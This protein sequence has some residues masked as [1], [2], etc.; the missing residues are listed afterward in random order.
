MKT[1]YTLNVISLMALF[2]MVPCA[3]AEPD[4]YPGDTSIYG[5]SSALQPNLLIALDTSSS[6]REVIS[7]GS[8]DSNTIY[9]PT[10]MGCTSATTG[11]VGTMNCVAGNVYLISNTVGDL[12]GNS[13][14][15]GVSTPLSSVSN[16]S[17]GGLT[18]SSLSSSGYH[19]SGSKQLN[20]NGSCGSNST[21][22]Y[23]TGNYLNYLNSPSS[24]IVTKADAAIRVLKNMVSSSPNIKFGLMTFYKDEDPSAT[25]G[26][27]FMN[28]TGAPASSST[29]YITSV[30]KMGDPF[31]TSSSTTANKNALMAAIDAIKF[32]WPTTS[33]P[34]GETTAIGTFPGQLLLEA[35]RSY[36]NCDAAGNNCGAPA[37]NS[38]I[39]V[40]SG[41]LTTAT[42]PIE[43]TCQKNYVILITDGL[44]NRDGYTTTQANLLKTICDATSCAPDGCKGTGC[45]NFP[46]GNHNTGVNN[47]TSAI[48][49]YLYNSTQNISTY[50]IGFGLTGSDADAIAMLGIASDSTHGRGKYYN[51]G[52]EA[53]LTKSLL[54]IVS[55]INEVNSTFV[56]PVVPVSPQNR[57]YGASRVYM[58]FFTPQTGAPWQ[59][60]LKKYGLSSTSNI[61]DSSTPSTYATWVDSIAPFGT[62]DNTAASI[63]AGLANGSF[64]SASQSYWSTTVDGGNVDKG[65]VGEKLHS[66]AIPSPRTIYT[67]TSTAS[68]AL[69]VFNATNVTAA[70]LGV[71]DTTARDKLVSYMY[72]AD[73]Y[74]NNSNSDTT[75]NRDW[76]MGDVLHSRPV[77]VNYAAYAFTSTNEAICA[78][79]KS[80]IFVGS[81]D[82]MLH[83]FKD[84]DGSEAWA[85]VPPD[86]LPTLQ[87]IPSGTGHSYYVDSSVSTYA[88]NK[89]NDG[90]IN[91]TNGDKVVLVFGEGR[92]GGSAGSPTTGSYYALNVSDPQTPTLMWTLSNATSGFSELAETWSEPKIVKMRIGTADK[93]AAVFG[94]GYDNPHEDGRYGAIQNFS[95]IDTGV[96]GSATGSGNITSSSGTGTAPFYTNAKGRGIYVVE[97]A[98]LSTGVPTL[99][100]TLTKIWSYTYGSSPATATT[101]PGLVYS[102]PTNLAT[103]DADS[104]GYTT[105]IYA[106]DTGGNMWRFNLSSTSTS[107]WTGTKIFSANPT[108]GTDI[109]RKIFYAPAVVSEVGYK[110]LFFGTGDREHPLNLVVT[111]RMY[112]L[113][114]SGQTVTKTE[115]NMLDVTS[116]QI[117]ETDTSNVAGTTLVANALNTLNSASNYGWYIKLNETANNGE[118]VLS[119]PTVFNKAAYFTTFKPGSAAT[120]TS[121]SSD[122]GVATLYALNYKNGNAVINYDHTNDSNATVNKNARNSSGEVL[123]KSDRKQSLG[124]GIPS[125]VVV[126]VGADGTVKALTSTGGNI[127]NIDPLKGGTII[128]MYWRQK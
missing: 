37:F 8:Y 25:G 119:A 1:R 26:G 69:A 113:K 114:D 78:T 86:L 24:I 64:R 103:I 127:I 96:A 77:V 30:K 2:F 40:V 38:T 93:I 65:G 39:G 11:N 31:P 62:D 74:D 35:G 125:G 29:P 46:I 120:T 102:F 20:S 9:T 43:A 115:S 15:T 59:G 56:A 13:I 27:Q 122:V 84:C 68:T 60:N 90:T 49:K 34:A 110:M 23:A 87:N 22:S 72:G 42:S 45:S 107:S 95:G 75:E 19:L 33:V 50:T 61:L 116:D 89:A 63:P 16:S 44:A 28:F 21:K 92:G 85:F 67:M 104:S 18:R 111:D 54:Q 108:T 112:G 5:V 57:T 70:M 32:A 71:A 100:S 105:R 14:A 117:Q 76:F 52:D 58:G 55:S 10:V 73:A 79:N 51:A 124:S 17:C 36:G 53:G 98:T 12:V 3:F 83:A 106:G 109:G 81:N 47:A 80:M 121:C 82:G 94:A 126:I 7:G 91:T 118:K 4:M 101:D 99:T 66:L 6:M 128:P 41:K 123:I 88:Y 48:A 97:L